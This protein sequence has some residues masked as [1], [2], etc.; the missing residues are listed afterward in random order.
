L[1][2]LSA[3]GKA[4]IKW[5]LKKCNREINSIGLSQDKN[6]LQAVVNAMMN[7]RVRKN[8]VNLLTSFEPVTVSGRTLLHGVS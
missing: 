4:T 8:A 5:I 3:D 1:E 2:D 7:I 6:R